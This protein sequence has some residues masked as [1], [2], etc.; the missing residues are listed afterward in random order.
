MR[1]GSRWQ[2]FSEKHS[3]QQSLATAGNSETFATERTKWRSQFTAGSNK[4]YELT[5]TNTA[6]PGVKLEAAPNTILDNVS[7]G[8]NTKSSEA[9]FSIP[10]LMQVGFEYNHASVYPTRLIQEH[11]EHNKVP[12]SPTGL[13]GTLFGSTV[14]QRDRLVLPAVPQTHGRAEHKQKQRQRESAT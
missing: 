13:L 8:E 10:E 4:Y 11:F 9:Q 12:S 7:K 6:H 1:A 2:P 5:S 14:Q 3:S